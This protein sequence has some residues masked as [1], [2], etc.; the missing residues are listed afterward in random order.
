MSKKKRFLK[1]FTLIEILISV[2]IIAILSAIIFMSVISF[3]NRQIIKNTTI[4]VAQAF[5]EAKVKTITSYNDEVYGVH[6]EESSVS[7]FAGE[8]YDADGAGTVV[9]FSDDS[10]TFTPSLEDDVVD[11][12]FDRLTGETTDTGTVLIE[13]VS[14][15]SYNETV[16]IQSSGVVSF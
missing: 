10:V 11:V 6:F 13:L 3:R 12:R 2:T 7:L 4:E 14:D 9:L 1:G 8:T 16:K 5:E 15:S